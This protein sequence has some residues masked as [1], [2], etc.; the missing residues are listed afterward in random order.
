MNQNSN[1]CS[2][3]D[4]KDLIVSSELLGGHIWWLIAVGIRN[5]SWTI[6]DALYLHLAPFKNNVYFCTFQKQC[7]LFHLSKTIFTL[8]ISKQIMPPNSFQDGKFFIRVICSGWID[9]W[10]EHKWLM[11]FDWLTIFQSNQTLYASRS[12]NIRK[13]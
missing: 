7:L 11:K 9:A 5:A 2:N 10:V 12:L 4:L 3:F 13:L 8:N 6:D 1:C